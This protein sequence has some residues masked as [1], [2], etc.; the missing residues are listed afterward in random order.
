MSIHSIRWANEAWPLSEMGDSWSLKLAL[1]P[2]GRVQGQ[3]QP[4]PIPIPEDTGYKWVKK[5]SG[6]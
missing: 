3:G 5:K 1:R 6:G 4:W 2:L